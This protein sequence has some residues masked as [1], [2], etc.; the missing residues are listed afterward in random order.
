MAK[1][2]I[3]ALIQFAAFFTLMFI[4]GNWDVI[5]LGQEVRAMQNHTTFFNPIDTIK[6]QVGAAHILILNGI[7]FAAVLLVLIVLVEIIA[8]RRHPW[9][10]LTVV[11]FLLAVA[12]ALLFKMGLPPAPTPDSSSIS[13][14][15][16]MQNPAL[17]PHTV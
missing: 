16:G 15:G 14:P 10:E 8:K 3:L 5:R 7:L 6:I 12:I 11:A 9:I 2:S 17:L 4:G 1:R 13:T